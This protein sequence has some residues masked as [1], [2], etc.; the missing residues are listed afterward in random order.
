[1]A[2]FLLVR[3]AVLQTELAKAI[4]WNVGMWYNRCVG[5]CKRSQNLASS[6]GYV[7]DNDKSGGPF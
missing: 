1:M 5:E 4:E 2:A 6:R 7:T 3:G